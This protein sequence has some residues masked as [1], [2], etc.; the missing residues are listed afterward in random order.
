LRVGSEEGTNQVGTA[1]TDE[2]ES[3]F[4]GV[5]LVLVIYVNLHIERKTSLFVFYT[6]GVSRRRFYSCLLQVRHFAMDRINDHESE[7]G[8]G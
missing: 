3:C 1:V 6:L 5:G 8:V 4:F 2:F 7:I